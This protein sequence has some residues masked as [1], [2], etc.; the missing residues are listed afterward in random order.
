M[1]ILVAGFVFLAAAVSLHAQS[2]KADHYLDVPGHTR[3]A[4]AGANAFFPGKNSI[5][6]SGHA[7]VSPLKVTL[8]SIDRTDF[9][10][11]DEF[12][13][14]VL[15]ENTG[16]QPITLPWSP[17]RGAFVQPAPRTPAGYLSGRLYLHV[18]SVTAQPVLLALLESQM[19]FGSDEVPRSRLIL[20]PGRTALLRVPAQWS[21]SMPE[22]RAGILKQPDGA[23]QVR[24]VFGI[25]IDNFP[26]TR[27]T[28]TLPVRVMPRTL[29]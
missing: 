23:V 10:Y 4:T 2:I 8:V 14:E 20:A 12:V 28:N 11:G 29:R 1:R 27:S 21:A 22:G 9:M 25:D 3:T 24:A 16:G 6:G 13:Y 7:I 15:I 19:L 26:L 5:A 18:E 17:D